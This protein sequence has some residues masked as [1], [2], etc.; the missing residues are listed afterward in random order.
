M[1]IV[2]NNYK[3]LN[4]LFDEFFN[5][6]PQTWNRE[7]NLTIPSVNIYETI[8]GYQLELVAPGLQKEEIKVNLEKGLL[9]ISYDKK[10]S[11]EEKEYK[12]LKKEF[13]LS[14][15]KRSFTLDD[16][17]N[18]EGIHAKYE[19]GILKLFLPKKDEV[20]VLTK[21]IAIS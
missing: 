18:N 8:N 16:N 7:A 5:N 12:T 6:V 11:N 4:N 17:I 3:S 9:S 10:N 19:N 14:S 20:K 1:T 15:F 13:C 2:K 21:E